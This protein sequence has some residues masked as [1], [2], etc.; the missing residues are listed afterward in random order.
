MKTK[1]NQ[2]KHPLKELRK[3]KHAIYSSHDSCK[4]L[5]EEI[6]GYYEGILGAASCKP[7]DD[8]GKTIEKQPPKASIKE[9]ISSIKCFK[10]LG[11]EHITS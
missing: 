7:K 1:D 11:R 6:C 4:S 2:T 10:C 9:K 3:E 5:S 8:K